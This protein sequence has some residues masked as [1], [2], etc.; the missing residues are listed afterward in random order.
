MPNERKDEDK[1]NRQ[2]QP[3]RGSRFT[4]PSFLSALAGSFG[5]RG[6]GHHRV[7][8]PYLKQLDAGVP[9]DRWIGQLTALVVGEL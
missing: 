1:R 3:A 8:G 2:L 7:F 4:A 9:C 6:F 5:R